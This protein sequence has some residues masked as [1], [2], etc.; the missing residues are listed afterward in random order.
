GRAGRV[1]RHVRRGLLGAGGHQFVVE[2]QGLVFVGVELDLLLAELDEPAVACGA[3]EGLR[4]LA[5]HRTNPPALA[6]PEGPIAPVRLPPGGGF[7]CHFALPPLGRVTAPRRK[8]RSAKL[9]EL[10]SNQ[11]P[12]D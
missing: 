5:W 10:D 4:E 6:G 3:E 8:S 11:Q 7:L 1:L 2:L 9:P 12:S